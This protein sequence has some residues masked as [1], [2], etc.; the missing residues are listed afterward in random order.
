MWGREEGNMWGEEE[1]NMWG[2]GGREYVGGRRKG[3]CGGGKEEGNMWGG[4]GREYGGEVGSV[5]QTQTK[6]LHS[7]SVHYLEELPCLPG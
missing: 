5:Q 2:G 1:G 7:F 6:I 3:I 4:G